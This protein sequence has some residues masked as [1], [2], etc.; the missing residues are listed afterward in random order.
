M[1]MLLAALAAFGCQRVGSEEGPKAAAKV[2][3]L[4]R[5]EAADTEG[6]AI[7]SESLGGT[8]L[9]VAFF[10]V[11]SVQS[12]RTL[13]QLGRAMRGRAAVIAI[14]SVKSD[15]STSL[16]P[17][18]LRREYGVDFPVIF[19]APKE[20]SKLF[21][22]PNCC[23]YLYIYDRGGVLRRA[24]RLSAA[25]AKLDAL[26]AE[27]SGDTAAGGDAASPGPDLGSALRVSV[28]A[29]GDE[30]LPVADDGLTVVNLFD[31]FCADCITGDRLQT[32]ERLTQSGVPSL[33]VFSE[34][35]FSAQDIENFR[36]MLPTR[37]AI[38][39]G[40]IEEA[41]TRLNNGRLLLVLDS[42]RKLL[43]EERPGMSEQ[44]ILAGV[45]SLAEARA[46]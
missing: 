36:L 17:S 29:A 37:C 1:T 30:P 27:L 32:L 16:A 21:E 12:W 2:G 8:P 15:A 6:R 19:D 25:Y 3:A 34:K 20:L 11:E 22:T 14:G 31:Q 43:W 28:E 39:R 38:R 44:D 23:D 7:R 40:D 13:A 41:R 10:E 5:F 46:R 45:R 26:A 18:A 4:P 24:E 35:N 33:A 42:R 9:A